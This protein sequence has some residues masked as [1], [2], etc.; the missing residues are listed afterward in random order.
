MFALMVACFASPLLAA[1]R[2][3]VSMPAWVSSLNFSPDSK[4]LALGCADSSARVLE[5]NTGKESIALHGHEDCVASVAFSPDGKTL[6]T[7]SYD[8]TARLWDMESNRPRQTLRGH[9]G[10][11]MSVA[12]SPDGKWLAT[13]SL[14]ATVKLWNATTGEWRAILPRL[15][16]AMA[17]R[18]S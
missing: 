18:A 5:T 6:A 16:F 10:V 11:V 9:R 8:H 12:F 7:G 15:A 4:R 13:G 3:S 2:F 17:P 14:D 1:G